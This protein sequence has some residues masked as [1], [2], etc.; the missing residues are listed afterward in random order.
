[1][2]RDREQYQNESSP[3]VFMKVADAFEIDRENLFELWSA[4]M[5]RR[6]V[7]ANPRSVICQLESH[8]EM[9][10]KEAIRYFT[11]MGFELFS[12]EYIEVTNG[13]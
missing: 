2:G 6:L 4:Y 3:K 5:A 11:A 12:K 7:G 10:Q 8:P 1:M 13:K 9:Y